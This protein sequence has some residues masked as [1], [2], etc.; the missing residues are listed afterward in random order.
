[1]AR[2]FRASFKVAALLACGILALIS[3]SAFPENAPSNSG[4]ATPITFGQAVAPLYGPWKFQV[5]DSPV[6]RA[7]N[8]LLWAEPAFNDSQWET[9]DLTPQPGIVDPFLADPAYVQGW[10]AKGH[11]GYSGYAWYRI[12]VSVAAEPGERLAVVTN[13]VDDGYQLFAQGE[14]VGS[15]GR[16]RDGKLPVVYFPQPRRPRCWRF[17][18]GWDRY[19]FRIIRSRGDSTMHRCWARAAQS[20]RRLIWN[21]WNWCD[22]MRSPGS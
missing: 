12:R 4:S 10:T 8:T 19:G 5:G 16:F 20:Q 22:I 21:G 18:C 2:P 3:P 15:M 7:T 11:P 1:M 6:D 14:L 13:G 9:V 17:V